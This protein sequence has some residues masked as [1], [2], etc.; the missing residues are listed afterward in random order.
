MPDCAAYQTFHDISAVANNSA[1]AVSAED[2]MSSAKA[3]AP[4]FNSV[5]RSTKSGGLGRLILYMNITLTIYRAAWQFSV[6][7]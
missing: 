7:L 6:S 5:N 4:P 1:K 3:T 2:K